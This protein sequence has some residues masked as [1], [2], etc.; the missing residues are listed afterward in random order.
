MAGIRLGNNGKTWMVYFRWEGRKCEFSTDLEDEERARAK[1]QDVEA[2][3]KL[4]LRK[5][6]PIPENVVDVPRWIATGGRDGFKQNGNRATIGTLDDLVTRYLDARKLR[7]GSKVKPLSHASYQSDVYRLNAFKDFCTSKGK[8][9]LAVALSPEVLG[10]YKDSLITSAEGAVSVRHKL[11][12][13]KALLLWAYEA[14]L[15][16]TL[17]RSIKKYN[18]I[19][20]PDPKPEF[21][22][23]K[24]AAPLPRSL[25]ANETVDSLGPQLRLH[26]SRHIQPC[27]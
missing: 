20:L 15:I 2:F 21:F 8:S 26:A 7:L 18:D 4:V 25:R 10:Q 5:S 23:V 19:D 11:R 3:R 22:T 24:E 27:P 6:L 12:T 16:D 1:A 17:P 13:V 14:E 9:K